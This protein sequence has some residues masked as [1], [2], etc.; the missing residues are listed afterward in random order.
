[1]ALTNRGE[2]GGGG[3]PPGCAPVADVPVPAGPVM[4]VHGEHVGLLPGAALSRLGGV[5]ATVI[6]FAVGRRGRGWSTV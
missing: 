4:P 1:M 6:G 2:M 3:H 5:G